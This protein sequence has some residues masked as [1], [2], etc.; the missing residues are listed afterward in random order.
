MI[1]I[2]VVSTICAALDGHDGLL[3]HRLTTIQIE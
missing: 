3:V 1:I 2:I